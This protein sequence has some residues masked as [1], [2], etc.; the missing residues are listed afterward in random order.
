MFLIT[1]PSTTKIGETV[2]VII[3]GAPAHV[4]LRD[5]AH[6]V[7]E[8]EPADIREI[9][10]VASKRGDDPMTFISSNAFG[11]TPIYPAELFDHVGDVAIAGLTFAEAVELLEDRELELYD[12]A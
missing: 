5:T 8:G 2:D 12:A 10:G 3:N 4:T 6:L 1:L 9:L 7:I 11:D